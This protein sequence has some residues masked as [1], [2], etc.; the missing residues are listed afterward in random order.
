MTGPAPAPARMRAPRLLALGLAVLL[1]AVLVAGAAGS[2]S[3]RAAS[4]DLRALQLAAGVLCAPG[5]DGAPG[6]PAGHAHLGD[7]C[8]PAVGHGNA[9][10]PPALR[11]R[12]ADPAA[13]AR[14]ATTATAA[15]GHPAGK[16]FVEARGPPSLA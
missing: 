11:A 3:L 15:P 1:G 6:H 2:V 10:P 13:F 16:E 8:C 5:E 12:L 7:C 9:A 4:A 14:G